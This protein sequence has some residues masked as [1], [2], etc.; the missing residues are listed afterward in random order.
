MQEEKKIKIYRQDSNLLSKS[1]NSDIAYID[2]PYNSRQ[3]SRFYHLYE[4]LVKWDKPKLEGVAMKPPTENSS[5]YSTSK[6]FITMSDL[7]SNLKTKQILISY[8]N[9]YKSNSNSSRIK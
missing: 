1:I 7:I 8:N 3:Y 9:T 6:A 5:A 2:P 4:N